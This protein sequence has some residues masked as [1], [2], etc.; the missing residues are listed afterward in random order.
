MSRRI[1]SSLRKQIKQERQ[2]VRCEEGQDALES[3]KDQ[4][5]SIK[6]EARQQA[7]PSVREFCF[8]EG[9]LIKLK[10]WTGGS[11]SSP[12]SW[13]YGLVIETGDFRSR[14]HH[15]KN[16]YLS[17]IIDGIIHEVSA[18]NCRKISE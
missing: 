9:E 10:K 15:E 17:V 3:I 14:R 5:K 8:E 6:R 1:P 11:G 4:K 16:A 12:Y 7:K 13:V 2:L 18:S